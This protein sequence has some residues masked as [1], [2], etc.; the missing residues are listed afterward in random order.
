[1]IVARRQDRLESLK[2]KLEQQHGIKVTVISSDL[3]QPSAS[4]SIYQQ[5]KTLG[6]MLIF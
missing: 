5:L 1:M 6:K 4:A 3:A 2:A